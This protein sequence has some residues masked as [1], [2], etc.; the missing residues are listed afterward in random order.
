[1]SALAAG[2]DNLWRYNEFL[3]YDEEAGVVL[4]C[5]AVVSARGDCDALPARK[6]VNAIGTYLVGANQNL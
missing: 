6:S 1:L 5:A 2:F 4:M 3:L